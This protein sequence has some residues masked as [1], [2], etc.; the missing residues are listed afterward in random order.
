MQMLKKL[1]VWQKAMDIAVSV[2]SI[3]LKFPKE[4]LFGLTSQIRR[5][6]VSIASNIAEGKGR[7]NKG[8]FDRFLDI[9]NGSRVELETQL[10][11]A[12]KIGYVTHNDIE[13][14][15]KELEEIGKMLYAL[16]NREI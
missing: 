11:I 12:E 8:D 10:L 9:A 16:K 14:C 2:Y 3:T 13:D 5:S 1:L 15:L 4:E 7:N 6:A